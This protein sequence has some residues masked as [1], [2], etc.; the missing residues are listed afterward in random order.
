MLRNTGTVLFLAIC[1]Q[2]QSSSRFVVLPLSAASGLESSGTWQPTK[3]DIDGLEASL[4]Q[5]SSLKAENWPA[6][7]KIRIDHPE[8]YF[9]QYVAVIR[10]GREE[11][12][13]NAL[14]RQIPM[15]D[16]RKGLIGVDDGG[17]CFWQAL[18]VPETKQYSGLRING[19]G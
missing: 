1:C 6:S 10:G 19:T 18:Y 8:Q 7:S 9:R 14:C 4:S 3:A 2:G 17:T 15:S 11:I 13:I 12:Y 5:I 16:W